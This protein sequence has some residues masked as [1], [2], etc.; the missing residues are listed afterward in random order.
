[1]D[2]KND[3]P[4]GPFGVSHETVE[5]AVEMLLKWIKSKA[6][7]QKSELSR[8]ERHICL[9]VKLK[10]I[11]DSK[12]AIPHDIPV[13]HPLFHLDGSQKICLIISGKGGLIA[14]VAEDKIKKEGLPV[15]KVF[16]YLKLDADNKLFVNKIKLCGSFDLF[17][18]DKAIYQLVPR[19]LG[20]AFFTRKRNPIP[21]DLTQKQWK[22]SMESACSSALLSIKGSCCVVRLARVSQTSKEIVENVVAVID[23]LVSALPKKWANI[24]SMY[25]KFM[26]SLVYPVYQSFEILHEI[27]SGKM[28]KLENN[29]EK[30][31]TSDLSSKKRKNVLSSEGK[32]GSLDGQSADDEVPKDDSPSASGRRKKSKLVGLQG[33]EVVNT[34]KTETKK[35]RRR[36]RRKGGEM[37]NESKKSPVRVMVDTVKTET[38]KKRRRNRRKEGEMT[39]ES[40]KSPVSVMVNTVK[41]ETKKKRRRNRRKEGEMTNESKKRP[42]RVMVDTV[43]T[44]T[45]KKR[46]RNR[47]KEGEMTNESKKSPVSVMVNTVETETKKKRRRR[48]KS[49]KGIEEK[50]C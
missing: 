50:P 40:K 8:H 20:P 47:R 49:D 32:N 13:P 28:V 11:P 37:T 10:T 30:R 46:L 34:V 35:K 48:R 3:K 2:K 41:T 18:A 36:N 42:V 4:Q 19:L 6:T 33:G 9:V 23:G 16:E 14:E 39:N 26:D 45:K 21:V 12:N 24:S 29:G 5:I 17:M 31:I 1:M 22:G 25:L 7:N 27:E 44:E 43:K 15:S 38:K